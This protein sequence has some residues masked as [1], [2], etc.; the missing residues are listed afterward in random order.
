MAMFKS[1]SSL[2]RALPSAGRPLNLNVFL[3]AN[4]QATV[5]RVCVIIIGK[6]CSTAVVPFL[7][8]SQAPVAMGFNRGSGQTTALSDQAAPQIKRVSVHE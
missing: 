6:M 5:Q 7:P 2:S 8:G 4:A 3:R 1:L